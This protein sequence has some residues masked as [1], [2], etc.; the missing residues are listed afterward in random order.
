M[1]GARLSPHNGL[2]VLADR[3]QVGGAVKFRDGFWTDGNIRLNGAKIAGHLDI[4][5]PSIPFLNL[6]DASVQTLVDCGEQ[7]WPDRLEMSG[8]EYKWIEPAEAGSARMRLRWLKRQINGYV[9]H[10][11]FQLASMYSSKGMDVDARRVGLADQRIRRQEQGRFKTI[12]GWIPDGLVGFGYKPWRALGWSLVLLVTG[13]PIFAYEH[14]AQN[15]IQ[16]TGSGAAVEFH[17][18]LYTL[19]LILPAVNLGQS[20]SWLTKGAATWL[21]TGWTIAGWALASVVVAGLAGVF[22]KS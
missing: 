12:I 13:T 17:P 1:N 20:G 7:S 14:S 5:N 6:A 9:P 2:S 15:L 3:L 4:G 22:R 11:Y 16:N 10:V 19:N 21:A 8:F 18:A